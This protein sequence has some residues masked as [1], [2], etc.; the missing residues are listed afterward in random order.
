MDD[1][2]ARLEAELK[3]IKLW[4]EADRSEKTD[5][6]RTEFSHQTLELRRREI[7]RELQSLSDPHPVV[8]KA[9]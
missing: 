1:R 7:M 2:R 3:A 8:R 4:D 6:A 9:S 5:H